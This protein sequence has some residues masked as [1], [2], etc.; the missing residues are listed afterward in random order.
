MS[1]KIPKDWRNTVTSVFLEIKENSSM[2]VNSN[3]TWLYGNPNKIGPGRRRFVVGYYPNLN[4]A[5]TRHLIWTKNRR[6][7]HWTVR[8]HNTARG[9]P[10]KVQD[11]Y[12][13]GNERIAS[14]TKGLRV[15]GITCVVL[16]AGQTRAIYIGNLATM[17]A[18]KNFGLHSGELTREKTPFTFTSGETEDHAD[19]ANVWIMVQGGSTPIDATI[20]II[21]GSGFGM[22]QQRRAR[23]QP[24]QLQN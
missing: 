24:P 20:M 15:I 22:Q 4:Q 1:G 7:S 10:A 2:E 5:I 8:P 21:R 23:V 17:E 16:K 14:V 13:N 12:W 9:K 6:R 18:I 11:L 3:E 19:V